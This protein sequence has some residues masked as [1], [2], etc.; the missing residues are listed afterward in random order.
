MVILAPKVNILVNKDI[1]DEINE[2]LKDV[3]NYTKNGNF[4]VKA[5]KKIL[6]E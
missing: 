3:G 5:K 2:V 1:D 6:D 4:K